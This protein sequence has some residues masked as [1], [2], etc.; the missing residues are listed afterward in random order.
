MF[1]E[2]ISSIE[3]GQLLLPPGLSRW[4]EVAL[5]KK[6]GVL[7]QP[8]MCWTGDRKINPPVKYLAWGAILSEDRESYHLVEGLA[9]TEEE[10]KIKP[11]QEHFDAAQLRTLF[12]GF[13]TELLAFASDQSTR[14]VLLDKIR[15]TV[16][17]ETEPDDQV[18]ER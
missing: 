14:Q 11:G 4:L 13:I 16:P 8:P 10:A 5:T 2:I 18:G 7:K 3:R 6:M 15:K 17:T 1:A 12:N 9:V